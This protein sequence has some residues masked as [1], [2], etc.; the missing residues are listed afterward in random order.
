MHVPDATYVRLGVSPL[1]HVNRVFLRL[2][3]GFDI[4][5]DDNNL[6]DELVRLNVGGGVDLGVVAVSLELANTASLDEF[7]DGDEFVHTLAFTLRFMGEQLQPFISAG[8]PLDDGVRRGVDF[9]IAGGI[10]V[11]P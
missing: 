4:G 3:A 10:Q 9:F 5:I 8:V 6:A 11:A 2:D 7:D 1:I